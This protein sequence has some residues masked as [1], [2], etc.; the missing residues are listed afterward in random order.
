MGILANIR[1]NKDTSRD[2]EDVIVAAMNEPECEQFE[3]LKSRAVST[4]YFHF[5]YKTGISDNQY[6]I[7][8]R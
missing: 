2:L 5:R 4:L 6:P 7:S 3:R 8:A 1:D